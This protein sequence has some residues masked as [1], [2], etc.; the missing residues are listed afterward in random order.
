ML[1]HFMPSAIINTT[2]LRHRPCSSVRS[3]SPRLELK[4]RL[5]SVGGGYTCVATL[6]TDLP[7]K[8]NVRGRDQTSPPVFEGGKPVTCD[9]SRHSSE[10]H[11]QNI[12]LHPG[13][14]GG[15]KGRGRVRGR[16]EVTGRRKKTSQLFPSFVGLANLESLTR[17][18]KG[19]EKT[20]SLYQGSSITL[21]HGKRLNCENGDFREQIWPPPSQL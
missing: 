20:R 3:K 8:V 4:T 5:G 21:E 12:L 1:R 6:K 16:A 18:E 13:R 14:E 2:A 17:R 11:T 15:R 19:K 10:T 9:N 7:A